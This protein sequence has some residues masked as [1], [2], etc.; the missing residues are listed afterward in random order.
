MILPV[1]QI[2]VFP[3]V[4][5]PSSGWGDATLLEID[6]LGEAISPELAM[7]DNGDAFAVWSQSNGTVQNVWACKFAVEEG[8]SEP[9][10]IESS[11]SNAET[12]EIVIDNGGNATAIWR[13]YNTS[14]IKYELWYNRYQAGTGWGNPLLLTTNSSSHANTPD[15]EMDS[16]GNIFLLWEQSSF[17]LS[18][19]YSMI[20]EEGIGWGIPTLIEYNDTALSSSPVVAV[21]AN[22]NAIAAWKQSIFPSWT[23]WANRYEK[24]DGWD[25]ATQIGPLAANGL[26]VLGADGAGNAICVWHHMNASKYEI[27]TN[28]YNVS[29]G[30][31]T[32]SILAADPTYDLGD[33]DI[34]VDENGN[35]IVVW[36]SWGGYNA[37]WAKYYDIETGWSSATLLAA[38]AYSPKAA[39]D[40][41]GNAI[42]LFL[43]DD[44]GNYAHL[45]AIRYD[46]DIGWGIPNL[47]SAN[48]LGDVGS[49]MKIAFDGM[50]NAIAVWKQRDGSIFNIWTNR[51]SVPDTEP[52]FLIISSPTDNAIVSEQVVT[53]T[54]TTEP[55]VTLNVNGVLAAVWEDGSFS[56]GISLLVGNNTITAIATDAA[57]NPTTRSL[58]ITYNPIATNIEDELNATQE[59]LGAALDDLGATKDELNATQEELGTA[60][61]DLETAKDELNATIDDVASL[62]SQSLILIAILAVIVILCAIMSIMYLSLRKK[63]GDIG[64]RHTER[65]SPP[66]PSN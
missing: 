57:G 38:L 63:I 10:L 23:I 53:V 5:E 12:P 3:A 13:Q 43:L 17:P 29:S 14:I 33:P 56:L 47:I 30:W 46:A 64:P 59:E 55:G 61:D 65:E 4:A 58:T 31:G 44:A 28:S 51:Y 19:I 16:E 7:N 50:G 22:G 24:G 32:A 45:W 15:M 20:Y 42:A 40:H 6:N 48:P 9:V 62:K 8:W 35:A 41:D 2:S 26:P 11:D 25:S 60:L 1:I 54:G 66:P 39:I 21:D 27:W 34:A 37:V 52:P 36:N 18:D 49:D